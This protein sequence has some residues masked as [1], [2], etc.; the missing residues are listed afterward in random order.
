[1]IKK[2]FILCGGLGTRLGELGQIT[3]KVLL[4]I[5]GKPILEYNIDL[6]KRHDITDIVL[7]TG[8]MGDHIKAYFDDGRAFDVNI[9]YSHE[10]EPMGTAGALRLARRF[11]SNTF[12]MCN[13]DELKDL[14]LEKMYKVHVKNKALVTIALTSVSNPQSYGV[15]EMEGERVIRFL[16]KPEKPSTKLIN[17]GLY[18]IDPEI[19]DLIPNGNVS[20][21]KIVFPKIAAMKRM[22]G[23]IF[24]GQWFPTDT[25]ERYEKA[26]ASWNPNL[27]NHKNNNKE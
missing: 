7:G 3:P 11:F 9:E 24:K 8:N 4:P 25:P 26:E 16:E 23:F 14:D 5:K 19:I 22:F 15:V 12:V 27:I 1:L 21:E 20:M 17:A 2:A 6:M 13:G 10:K 18:M